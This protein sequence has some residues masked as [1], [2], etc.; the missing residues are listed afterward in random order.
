MAVFQALVEEVHCGRNTLGE[1]L[2]DVLHDNLWCACF[3]ETGS[4]DERAVSS[5][6]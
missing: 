6:L 5:L 2:V 3:S 4:V 1:G